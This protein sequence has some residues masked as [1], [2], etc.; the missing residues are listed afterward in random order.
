MPMVAALFSGAGACPEERKK[1]KLA[2][3]ARKEGR[4]EVRKCVNSLNLNRTT[5]PLPPYVSIA[6]RPTDSLSDTM[7]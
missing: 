7:D 5:N 6:D 3:R 1:K 2:K 4:K